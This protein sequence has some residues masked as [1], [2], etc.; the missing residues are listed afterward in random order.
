MEYF[1]RD[2]RRI[3]AM[4]E[5]LTDRFDGLIEVMKAMQADIR[6]MKPQVALIPSI[7]Q[8]IED[9]KKVENIH[10]VQIDN[11]EGRITTLEAT[12]Q[13]ST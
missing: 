1:R 13:P 9:I 6:E 3:E 5:I 8:T 2:I 7:I 10:S 11:H 4:F 12:A